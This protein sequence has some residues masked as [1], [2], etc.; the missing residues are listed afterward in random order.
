[1]RRE[2]LKTDTT[3]W[4]I[5]P[6]HAALPG[7]L[8]LHI[9]LDGEVVLGARVERGFAHRGLEKSMERRTWLQSLNV[10][11]R[12]DPE[13][14][15]F[16]ELAYA[17]AVEA[18][19]EIEIPL[20]AQGVRVVIS[21]LARVSGHLHFVGRL[22]RQVGAETLFHYAFR[23]REKILDLF[24]LLTG[25]RHSLGFMR[26]GGVA[27]EVT[28]GFIERVLDF[29][30]LIQI[31]FKE[32]ND[33]FS[34]SQ[35]LIGRTASVGVLDPELGRSAGVTGPNIRAS[36]I[37]M[38]VRKQIPYCGYQQIDFD[39]SLGR[40]EVGQL[41]DTHDRL[42]VRIR[43]I[44]ASI[45]ILRQ[46][47]ES[48]PGGPYRGGALDPDFSLP[49]GEGYAR[50]ESARGMLNCHVVSEGGKAPARVSFRTPTQ[51]ALVVLPKLV[52]GTRLE[53]LPIILESLDLSMAEADK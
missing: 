35:A 10:A 40:G 9:E 44:A 31:R 18:L 27:A 12:L 16:G 19:G 37:Y 49:A 36:G 30:D 32:Y 2:S 20:R 7:P 3:Q 22:A 4:V 15:V 25:A 34:F 26:F 8:R 47:C 5:G 6:Y 46:V 50:V 39:V 17:M 14:S 24:E 42:I 13:G 51:A 28:D 11:G 21:E 29:C 48:M 38:D 23:D 41:G 1:M 45:R 43:E 33:L 53:D 52:E